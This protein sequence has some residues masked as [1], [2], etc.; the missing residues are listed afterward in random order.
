MILAG[1]VIDGCWVSFTVTVK[2]QLLW[3]PAV[4]EA[5]QLT[6]V[7]PLGKTEPLAGVHAGVPTP[8]QLSEA[9]GEKLTTAEHCPESLP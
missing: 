4:S 9:A 3:L 2:L 5:V 6:V 1:Q 7:V 8:E